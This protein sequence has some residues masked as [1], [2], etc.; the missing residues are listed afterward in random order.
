MWGTIASSVS[1]IA[2]QVLEARKVKAEA[3]ARIQVAKVEAEIKQIQTSAE[4]VTDYDI[5]ALKETRYSYKDEIALIVVIAPFIGSFLP[6]TQEYVA[7]G[8]QH[9]TTHAPPWYGWIF[10]GAIAGSMGIRWAVTGLKKK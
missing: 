2:S 5:Q 10:C 9:L 8:W 3:K 6:W 7:L 1:S 4:A